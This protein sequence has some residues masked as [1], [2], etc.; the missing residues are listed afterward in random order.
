MRVERRELVRR[1]SRRGDTARKLADAER[2]AV[3]A[4]ERWQ[5]ISSRAEVLAERIERSSPRTAQRFGNVLAAPGPDERDP[6]DA[7]RAAG[8]TSGAK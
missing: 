4:R 1:R 3:L 5:Q 2:R 6:G 8:A 7:E